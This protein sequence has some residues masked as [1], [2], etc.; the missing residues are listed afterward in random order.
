MV[1]PRLTGFGAPFFVLSRRRPS[2][3][4]SFNGIAAVALLPQ[5]FEEFYALIGHS[6]GSLYSLVRDDGK[7]LARYPQLR[8]RQRGLEPGSGLH[9]AIAEGWERVIYTIPHSQLDPPDRRVRLP[10]PPGPP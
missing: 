1:A 2:V 8:D 3:D 4:G 5:Y 7:F 9:M 10:H 6:S